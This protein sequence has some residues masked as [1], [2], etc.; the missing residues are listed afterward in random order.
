[1]SKN[2]KNKVKVKKSK[3]KSKSM[4]L[5]SPLVAYMAEFIRDRIIDEL[6]DQSSE[7]EGI[8]ERIGEG[9]A[10]ANEIVSVLQEVVDGISNI[11]LAAK[12][13]EEAAALALAVGE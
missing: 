5:D 3:S 10:S 2:K 9:D 11:V 1:M 7:I 6:D 4:R 13:V 8:I 12:V